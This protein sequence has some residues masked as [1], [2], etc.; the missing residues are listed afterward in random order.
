MWYCQQSSNGADADD[1]AAIVAALGRQLAPGSYVAISHLTG[2][3]APGPV[4][5]GVSAYNAIVPT[6]LI[7]RTHSKVSAL[8]ADLPLVPP[9]VVPLAEWRSVPAMRSP[10]SSDMYAGAARGCAQPTPVPGRPA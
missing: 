3:F 6:A 9:G 10:G 7:P 1:P 2:D 5:A 4:G 8:F